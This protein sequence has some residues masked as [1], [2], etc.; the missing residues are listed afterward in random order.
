MSL[1]VHSP[2]LGH[3]RLLSDREDSPESYSNSSP[4]RLRCE[5]RPVRSF[6]LGKLFYAGRA[7]SLPPPIHLP[8]MRGSRLT[9]QLLLTKCMHVS[10]WKGR[11]PSTTFLC[12]RACLAST[13]CGNA[14]SA[15]AGD[16]A[17]AP[18]G[19]VV[20][21]RQDRSGQA[22]PSP[23]SALSSHTWTQR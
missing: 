10:F 5:L 1:S 12:D 16:L 8:Q 20:G 6:A 3:K 14:E 17:A 2:Y 22:A 15:D 23:P 19:D 4:K 11:L 7:K 13:C 9:C 18:P 21:G